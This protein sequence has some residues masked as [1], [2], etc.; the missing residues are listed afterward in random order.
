MANGKKAAKKSVKRPEVENEA[1]EVINMEAARQKKAVSEKTDTIAGITQ[2]LK[3]QLE[4]LYETSSSIDRTGDRLVVPRHM[5][6]KDAARA[7]IDWEK[8][9]EEETERDTEWVGHP[10]DLL[11]A[12][13]NGLKDAFGNVVGTSIIVPGFFGPRKIAAQTR[14]VKVDFDESVTVPTGAISLPG[15]PVDIRIGVK[16]Q[17]PINMSKGRMSF[18]YKNKYQPLVEK[19]EQ[20]VADRLE[21]DSIFKSKALNSKFEFINPSSDAVDRL[22]YSRQEARD[23]ETHIFQPIKNTEMLQSRGVSLKRTVLLWGRFGTGK[24]LTALKA[25][26]VCLDNGWTFL[27]VVPGDD[28]EE[29]LNFARS[30]EPCLVFFEDIDQVTSGER[31]QKLNGILN[32]IDGALSKNAKIMT[33]LTTNNTDEIQKAM[34]RPGRIDALIEMGNVDKTSFEGIVRAYCGDALVGELDTD[35]LMEIAV[36]YTP[37]FIAEACN[38]AVMYAMSRSGETGNGVEITNE[39]IFDSLGGLRPQYDLM[40]K[41]RIEKPPQIE[42]ILRSLVNEIVEGQIDE[43]DDRMIDINETVKKIWDE[44]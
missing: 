21:N 44:M 35:K 11:M 22:V 30:Y 26:Q 28:V 10:D 5:T 41:D 14:M 2:I 16:T 17:T 34:L 31:D 38:R 4:K 19:I 9:M 32:T 8:R 18:A 43:L 23:I 42:G 3:T 25:A 37:S 39:D 36:D 15:V 27:N 40:I 20:C 29:A 1:I 33:I 13:F 6:L 24:T 12:M 7:L